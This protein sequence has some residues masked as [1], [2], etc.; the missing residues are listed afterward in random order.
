MYIQLREAFGWE[1]Y[2][3]VFA[4]YEALPQSQQPRTEQ[5]QHD[6]WMTRMSRATKSNL[7][8]FFRAWGVPVSAAAVDGLK[9]LPAWMPRDWPTK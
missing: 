9:D 2:K 7:G 3:Q 4:E 1:P 6:Q 5:E 8:P